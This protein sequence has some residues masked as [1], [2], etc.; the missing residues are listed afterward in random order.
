MLTA[1]RIFFEACFLGDIATDVREPLLRDILSTV[2][3]KGARN[4]NALPKEIMGP[5][6]RD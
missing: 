2:D 3:T 4:L 1:T 5:T 6:A